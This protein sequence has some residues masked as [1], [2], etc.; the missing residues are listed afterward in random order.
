MINLVMLLEI[1]F[2]LTQSFL[3]YIWRIAYHHIESALLEDLSKLP[4]PVKGID[5]RNLLLTQARIV[6]QDIPAD[7]RVP[8]LM[9]LLRSGSALSAKSLSCLE[10]VSS[11]SPSSTLSSSESLVTSTACRSMSTP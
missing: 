3:S 10:I 7:Q 11:F 5:P 4:L 2:E 8:H 9:F 1:A 6:L